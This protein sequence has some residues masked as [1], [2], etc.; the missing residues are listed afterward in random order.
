MSKSWTFQ[1][2]P[3]EIR[4][5]SCKVFM[6]DA[7][8]FFHLSH[9]NRCSNHRVLHPECGHYSF[10]VYRM[11]DLIEEDLVCGSFLFVL[12]LT[13]NSKILLVNFA[14]CVCVMDFIMT[15]QNNLHR[16]SPMVT[17]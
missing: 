1:D 11:D 14:V 2:F 10:V 5:W 4:I 7:F 13:N 12:K 17:Q 8:F 15:C 3:Y 6:P 16:L 9:L